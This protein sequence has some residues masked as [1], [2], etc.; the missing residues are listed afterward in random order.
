LLEALSDNLRAL[1]FDVQTRVR[2]YRFAR[3]VPLSD[4][5]AMHLV[6][7]ARRLVHESPELVEKMRKAAACHE[8]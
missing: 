2:M 3:K 7:T 1:G 8:G 6:N 4:L 5:H